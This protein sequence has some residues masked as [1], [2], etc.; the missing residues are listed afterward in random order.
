MDIKSLRAQS[1]A[2]LDQL[3]QGFEQDKGGDAKSYKDDRFWKPERDKA[4]NASAT[5]RFLPG[6]PGELPW[7]KIFSHA[8]KG[9]GGRWYIENS[10][11]TLGQPDPVGELNTKLWNSVD[12]DNTPERKQARL[13][14]RKLNYISNILVVNDPK[15]PEN[16]GK[17]FLFKYGKK[18]FDRIQDKARPTF[19]DQAPVNVFDWFT[20]ANFK[21]RMKTVDK[22]PN[23]DSSEW[24]GESEIGDDDFILEVAKARHNLAELMDPKNFKSYDELKRKLESV[25]SGESAPSASDTDLEDG[26][27]STMPPRPVAP[28]KPAPAP[29]SR[30]AS[31]DDDDDEAM[32]SYFAQFADKNDD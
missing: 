19:E 23:Y 14:K 2:G 6:E 15:H 11:T 32:T 13:Q 4:G 26:G 12:S 8:F 30:P 27:F 18:I 7:V 28:S 29:K 21:L 25:L 5:I 1:K 16:N 10:L 22:M 20:G 31:L 17:V 3:V 9:P 24:E